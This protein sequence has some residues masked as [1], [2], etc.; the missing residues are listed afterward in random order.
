VILASR[1]N[2]FYDIFCLFG[3]KTF[4]QWNG[5]DPYVGEAESVMTHTAGQVYM[6]QAV[7]CVVK[8]TH[9][10]FLRPR[11]VIDVVQQMGLT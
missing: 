10:V 6:P 11:S 5:W 8:M 4:G 1:A 9:A 7:A 3:L 2:T